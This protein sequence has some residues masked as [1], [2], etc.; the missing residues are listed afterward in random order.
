MGTL[1]PIEFVHS[2]HSVFTH[3]TLRPFFTSS[4]PSVRLRAYLSL[5]TTA[6]QAQVLFTNTLSRRGSFSGPVQT[7]PLSRFL[8]RSNSPLLPTR[9]GPWN[10]M[11]HRQSPTPITQ[12][13]GR[14]STA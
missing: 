5:A 10:K 1:P 14:Q 8:T 9:P 7:C 3:P 12:L 13:P 6:S 2:V 4:Y 11:N